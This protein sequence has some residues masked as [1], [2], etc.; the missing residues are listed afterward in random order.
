MEK[1]DKDYLPLPGTAS[2]AL[3]WRDADI[4]NK[5][6]SLKNRESVI[7]SSCLCFCCFYFVK[8]VKIVPTA[9]IVFH[10]KF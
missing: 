3:Q 6:L 9:N 8:N 10:L 1:W 5:Y 2:V 7:R 4:T